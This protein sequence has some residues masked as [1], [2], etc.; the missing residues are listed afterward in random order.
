MSEIKRG[1]LVLRDEMAEEVTKAD[2][3]FVWLKS[4]Y[5]I[6]PPSSLSLTRIGSTLPPENWR[7]HTGSKRPAHVGAEDNVRVVWCDGSGLETPWTARDIELTGGWEKCVAYR[8]VSRAEQVNSVLLD[9]PVIGA[10]VE[11]RQ[12]PA[13]ELLAVA[14]ELR[15]SH[16]TDGFYRAQPTWQQCRAWADRL[17]PPELA[18]LRVGDR[19]RWCGRMAQIKLFDRDTYAIC[20]E[21]DDELGSSF[22]TTAQES[23]LERIP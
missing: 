11:P 5:C 14:A 3:G 15:Q 2:S 18:P 22:L 8:L 20:V 10:V 17:D 9:Q 21:D 16:M 7:V 23:E 6:G 1:D 12:V 19:V 13:S 4:G